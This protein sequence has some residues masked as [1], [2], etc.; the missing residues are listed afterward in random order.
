M[1]LPNAVNG[2]P[3]TRPPVPSALFVYAL[4]HDDEATAGVVGPPPRAHK[5]LGAWYGGRTYQG[6]IFSFFKSIAD[7]RASLK[8]LASLEGGVPPA[9][10]YRSA[11]N[12]GHDHIGS[13]VNTLALAYFGGALPLVLLLSLGFQPLSVALNGEEIVGS[14]FTVLAASI[15]LVLCVPI[16]TAIAVYFARR[17]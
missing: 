2:L 3:P 12:V 15:G 5:Q 16:T 14:I 4:A 13:L 11:L 7:A 9:L 8:S 10:L 1:S 17:V 6:I